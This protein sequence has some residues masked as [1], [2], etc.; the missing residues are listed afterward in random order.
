MKI[1]RNNGQFEVYNEDC[2]Q[3]I[4]NLPEA[5]ID[6]ILTDP[7]YLFLKKHRLERAF[8]ERSVFTEFSRV[9]KPKGFVILFGRGT[10]FYRWNT[11]LAEL[12]FEFKEEVIWDKGNS[13]SPLMRMAR[14]HETISLHS[15]SGVIHRVKVPYLEMREYHIERIISDVKIL[16]SAFSNSKSFKA[17]HDFL[18]NNRINNG[19]IIRTDRFETVKITKH[20]T[21]IA[22]SPKSANRC[23]NVVQAMEFGL[24]EK[25]IIKQVRDHYTAIHPTQ[26]PVKLLERLLKI[27][28]STDDLVLD[29]FA[30]SC[31]T[32]IACLNTNRRF[33]G[34]EIDREYYEAGISR[35]LCE[36]SI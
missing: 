31:S 33:V 14:I 9:L 5:S 19:P 25:S 2:Q 32:G 21:S 17:V 8:D 23:A 28:T 24:T 26:K 3:A 20:Q 11:I 30:G 34:Y 15:K 16:M 27:V 7:P 35:L 18:E 29:P 36:G 4:R 1:L 12:G 22:N 10:S 13:T 6:C